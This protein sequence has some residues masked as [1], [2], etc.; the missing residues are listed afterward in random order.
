MA[1]SKRRGKSPGGKK[2]S[3]AERWASLTWEDLR[4]WAG[5]RS[6]SRGRS[7]HRQNRVQDLAV[8]EDGQL[9][10]TV[11]GGDRYVVSVWL[12]SKRGGDAIQ[13]H[14]TCP[15]GSNGCKHAVAAV[16][17]YL[18]L[19]A[20]GGKAP[21]AG[22]EDPRWS[23]LTGED[24]GEEDDNWDEAL[25]EDDEGRESSSPT[26]ARRTRKEWDEKI[27]AHISAKSRED[28]AELVWLLTDR[29]PEL[30][31]E[32]RECI[33]LGEGDVDRLVAQARQELR[34]VTSEMGWR[35]NWTGEGHTPDFSRLQQ[36]LER[37]V[38]LGHPDAVVP[39]GGELIER[40]IKQVGQSDDEGK[41]AYAIGECLPVVFKAVAESSL[42]PSQKLL[43]AI[44]ASLQDDYDVIQDAADAVLEQE[45]RPADWSAVAD[46]LARRLNAIPTG[47][48]DNFHQRYHRD[49]VS[50]WLVDALDRAGRHD[51]VMAIYENEART[52]GS[53]E[54]LV[55]VLIA[56]K[57]YD[58]A[59]QW[60]K[61]GIEKTCQEW[62]G[63][64]SGLA[65]A[66]CEVAEHRKE[67]DVVAAHAAW[68]FFERPSKDTFKDLVAASAK[69]RCREKIRQLALEFLETGVRP[70]GLTEM[71]KKK[72]NA[73]SGNDWPLPVPEYLLPL[74]ESRDRRPKPAQPH[75][76]V[77]IDIAIAEK[78]P[79]DVLR[80][81]DK[82]AA[83]RKRPGGGWASYG[84]GF[85]YANRVAAAVCKSH[86]ERSVAIYRQLVDDALPQAH[87]SAYEAVASHLRK[88]RPILKSVKREDEWTQLLAD[89]RLRYRNRPK[90]M[91]ILD[92]LDGRTIVESRR[93]RR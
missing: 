1:R 55:K 20:D 22:P 32:F 89:I 93:T 51:E 41:T 40:G 66:L 54:R 9:L 17:A 27:R 82:M 7:Y 6:V 81:Y 86:P 88:M 44:D 78:R 29:F 24:S 79:D 43:F 36:R 11:M 39:L 70:I 38:E 87:V 74:L 80:W 3:S 42:P 69:A 8:T 37:L 90:F 85:D 21:V 45:F 34:R 18:G 30:R 35:N 68:H 59:E 26:R 61:E 19:L 91:E 23:R 56:Q 63:I 58:Q 4:A 53:Y 10:A 60:A 33:A 52:T 46:E 65:N 13:S 77:L 67:W 14:C 15:V 49:Q 31:E 76:D 25:E 28:L 48:K 92:G 50:G 2:R 72:G 64:A 75:Y 73:G 62:P 83:G 57:R 16:A 12:E 47:P 71:R 5:S 84:W